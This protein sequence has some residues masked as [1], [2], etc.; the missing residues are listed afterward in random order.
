MVGASA[1]AEATIYLAKNRTNNICA[2]T[3][4]SLSERKNGVV[5]LATSI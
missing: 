1:C 3:A 2:T 5:F 4:T